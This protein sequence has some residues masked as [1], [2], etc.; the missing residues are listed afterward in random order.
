MLVASNRKSWDTINSREYINQQEHR[1]QL[2]TQHAKAEITKISLET[3]ALYSTI[4]RGIPAQ[5]DASNGKD[6]SNS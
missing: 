1:Q 5:G 4:Q 3:T 6:G 2:V